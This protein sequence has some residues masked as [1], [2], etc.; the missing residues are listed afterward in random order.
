MGGL[1]IASSATVTVSTSKGAIEAGYGGL[2]TLTL[3]GLDFNSTA[4]GINV[5]NIGNYTTSPAINILG[6]NLFTT[7]KPSSINI[8]V[9]GASPTTPGT[10]TAHLLKYVGSISGDGTAAFTSTVPS[11]GRTHF[12]L[13]FSD[14]GYVD[15]Q[16]STDYPVWTGSNGNTWVQAASI[17]PSGAT[18]WLSASAGTAT[19]FTSLDAPL[20]SDSASSSLVIVSSANVTPTLVTFNNSVLKYTLSGA[21]GITD[22]SS[23]NKASLVK[24]GAA[25]LTI[26]NSNGYSGG[27]T[28]NAGLL[29]ASGSDALGTG[30]VTEN[31]G[32]LAISGPE[33][34]SSGTNLYAG[35]LNA[36]ASGALGTGL[37]SMSG[38]TAYIAALQNVGSVSLTA[39]LLSA[40][41]TGALGLGA[42]SVGG[43]TANIAAPQSVSYVNMT[44]GLLYANAAQ[45]LGT[46]ALSVSVGTLSVNAAQTISG[47]TLSSGLLNFGN[48][49][50][51]GTG[52]LTIAG[53]SFDNSSGSALTLAN[54][55]G[56]IWNGNFTFL[57]SKPL[58]TGSGN[59]TLGT[60]PTVTVN[61]STLTIGGPISGTGYGLT[62]AGSG[63]LILTASNSYGGG[64]TVSSG[65]L[66][67]GDGVASAG[68]VTG[69]I[70]NNTSVVFAPPSRTDQVY[71]GIISGNGSVTKI[72]G[73]IENLTNS[74]T[75]AGSTVVSNGTLQLGAVGVTD[76]G[77]GGTGTGWTQNGS[78]S[79]SGNVLTL[80]TGA[81]Q[82]GSTFF[83]SKVPTGAFTASFVYTAV[84]TNGAMADGTTFVLQN[85]SSGANALGSGGGSVGYQGIGS[86]VA[87]GFVLY[88]ANG[89]AKGTS[90]SSG[91]SFTEPTGNDPNTGPINF[92]SISGDPI[93]VV[94]SYDGS[95]TLVESMTDENTLGT[96]SVSYTGENIAS[97]TG[98]TSAYL[99]FTGASG[100]VG[101]TQ[102]ISNFTFTTG[103]TS[104][105]GS[106][107][108]PITTAV[109][110]SNTG[111]LDLNGGTQTLMSLS[112]IVPGQGG[113]IIN[114]NALTPA[115]LTLTPSGSTTYSGSIVDS[116]SANS[117][118]L[119]IDGTGT[120]TLS[121]TNSF[122][123]GTYVLEGTLVLDGAASL[124]AGSSLTIGDG[125]NT[126]SVILSPAAQARPA[127]LAPAPEPATIVLLLTG[128]ILIALARCQKRNLRDFNNSV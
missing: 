65:T 87:V 22:P 92:G 61:A 127:N 15:I 5:Y 27:T 75:Y 62:S 110:I 57:G 118:T 45:A 78:G 7:Y 88:D 71:T 63:T 11:S 66:Q 124:L 72:G 37:L 79:I 41:G 84:G 25:S 47:G 16:I 113:S 86:S 8:S 99:G 74:H 95:S 64:T 1:G 120:Q 105:T 115:L 29:A 17:V 77:F 18:N 102:T 104:S 94:L 24:N 128:S 38:G 26:T 35:L 53:G 23:I 49:A 122:S 21:Y 56:Q 108:L 111:T 123:G 43:G 4:V 36:T 83:D 109:S 119:V 107:I 60:S 70:S 67:L 9:L 3:K 48:A 28:L 96:F 101:S 103:V 50:A 59:I 69:N 82:D 42:L 112:D 19:N 126:P 85:S 73:G 93:Q 51:L 117:I 12:S 106:N 44:G 32:T 89:G 55:G 100:A 80:I 76:T 68:S 52:K 121:G 31:G 20:F 81:G 90:F 10:E 58:N 14:P 34:Y 98:G 13:I 125:G 116:G 40:S 39:G 54:S 33:N 6:S 46:G 30:F 114:S 91:G 2:G 97:L